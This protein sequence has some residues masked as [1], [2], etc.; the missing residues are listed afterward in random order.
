MNDIY[1]DNSSTSFPKATNVGKA[2][3]AFIEGGAFNINRGSY[4]GAYE[5]G[6]EVL[7]TRE[8]LKDLFNCSIS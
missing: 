5:I 1:F 3:C 8:M 4:E 7:E 6:S 2:M